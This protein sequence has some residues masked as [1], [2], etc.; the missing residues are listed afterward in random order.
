M[1]DFLLWCII[2]ICFIVFFESEV[3]CEKMQKRKRQ[4]ELHGILGRGVY[5]QVFSVNIVAKSQDDLALKL[6]SKL[7]ADGA[8]TAA[9]AAGPSAAGAA[10]SAAG[11]AAPAPAAVSGAAA[12]DTFLTVTEYVREAYGLKQHGHFLGFLADA[13]GRVGLLMPKM[14]RRLG[15]SVLPVISAAGSAALLWPVAYKL[16]TV[17]GMHRDIKPA[18]I[19]LPARDSD[20]C[21]LID[22]SL[23]THMSESVDES[24]ITLWYRPPE[25]IL[26]LKYSQKADIWSFGMVLLGIL[27][28]T[29]LNRCATEDTKNGFLIDLLDKFGWPKKSEW[30]ELYLKADKMSNAND[31]GRIGTFDYGRLVMSLNKGQFEA[32]AA[33]CDLLDK[34]LCIVPSERLS[35]TGIVAHPFWTYGDINQR[36]FGPATAVPLQPVEPASDDGPLDFLKRAHLYD[37]EVSFEDDAMVDLNP[38]APQQDLN[39]VDK[40]MMYGTKLK[41]SE[42]TVYYALSIWKRAMATNKASVTLYAACLYIAGCFNEDLR[43]YDCT[44]KRWAKIFDSAEAS[45]VAFERAAIRLMICSQ[46]YWPKESWSTTFQAMKR[47]QTELFPL[48][49]L[50]LYGLSLDATPENVEVLK[51]FLSKK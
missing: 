26:G 7:K 27:T 17:P 10:L 14:G 47:H 16:S 42:C 29:H 11:A 45:A 35:W 49:A 30:P 22:F 31:K 23:A 21:C 1:L 46:A 50:Y 32:A 20:E 18:N 9:A 34:I 36:P 39:T 41:F 19:L 12:H 48:T 13:S 2:L 25:V 24:V 6:L 3:K 5:G 15:N 8:A 33:A 44:W 4:N 38:V 40:I 51:Q 43:I 28:G 37:T